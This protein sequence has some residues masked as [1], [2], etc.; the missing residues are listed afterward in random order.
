LSKH[1]KNL[2][3]PIDKRGDQKATSD[4]N[5]DPTILFVIA[6]AKDDPATKPFNAARANVCTLRA[7]R[8]MQ[9][10]TN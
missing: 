5:H 10:E 9:N 1:S 2:R 6:H 8:F 3:C 7:G 4:M